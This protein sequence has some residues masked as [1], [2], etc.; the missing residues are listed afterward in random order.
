MLKACRW[1][2]ISLNIGNWLGVTFCVG[3]M[4]AVLIGLE[5]MASHFD[6]AA[7]PGKIGVVRHLFVQVM[8]LSIPMGTATDLIFR[9][10]VT[11]IDTVMAG[12]PF[13]RENAG[14]LRQIAWAML[15]IQF[16]DLCF[17]RLLLAGE[18]LARGIPGWSP[19][20][21]GWIAV[22]LLFVLARVF[23]QGADMQDEIEATV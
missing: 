18:G 1:I 21:T 15:V 8:A 19:S 13:T 23:T 22:L 12:S 4:I 16:V 14:R 10:L 6:H 5:P 2:L 20:A 7:L 9:R 11:M 3:M 17:G